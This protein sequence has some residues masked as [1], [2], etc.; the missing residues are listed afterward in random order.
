MDTRLANVLARLSAGAA[1]YQPTVAPVGQ[2]PAPDPKPSVA[3]YP[4][5][6]ADQVNNSTANTSEQKRVVI[7]PAPPGVPAGGSFSLGPEIVNDVPLVQSRPAE[8]IDHQTPVQSTLAGIDG[9]KVHFSNVVKQANTNLRSEGDLAANIAVTLGQDA[10][11]STEA[12]VTAVSGRIATARIAVRKGALASRLPTQGMDVRLS[13]LRTVATDQRNYPEY[14]PVYIPS[15]LSDAGGAALVSLMVVG[16]PG[17]YVWRYPAAS[18]IDPG[19]QPAGVRWRWPGGADRMLVVTEDDRDWNVVF[20]GAAF[21]N[22]ALTEVENYYRRAW[23]DGIFDEGW[24]TS[25]ALTGVYARP[26]DFPKQLGLDF[27]AKRTTQRWRIDGEDV[28]G[29]PAWDGPAVIPPPPDANTRGVFT[30]IPPSAAAQL[31]RVAYRAWVAAFGDAFPPEAR[32]NADQYASHTID[33]RGILYTDVGG[34][35]WVAEW[36]QLTA[37]ELGDDVLLPVLRLAS[38]AVLHVPFGE[39]LIVDDEAPEFNPETNPVRNVFGQND[40]AVLL[41]PRLRVSSVLALLAGIS[42]TVPSLPVQ[43]YLD[44]TNMETVTT[45]FGAHLHFS[46][47]MSL[48][49]QHLEPAVLRVVPLPGAVGMLGVPKTLRGLCVPRMMSEEEYETGGLECLENGAIFQTF[50]NTPYAG[51]A[52]DGVWANNMGIV[53]VADPGNSYAGMD[54]AFRTTWLSGGRIDVHT[55]LQPHTQIGVI[56]GAEGLVNPFA[57]PRFVRGVRGVEGLRVQAGA[58]LNALVAGRSIDAFLWSSY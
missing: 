47:I 30:N 32:P 54:A 55:R 28:D 9:A 10:V 4:E 52:V 22:A 3:D 41:L 25:F 16:G 49:R 57:V 18:D 36:A 42:V 46:F 29:N 35:I 15:G 7:S 26:R 56:F 43:R 8:G 39:G 31:G 21:S 34:H 24:R 38:R 12:T 23:G 51:F 53:D 2:R 13:T 6:E 50:R 37:D 17:A 11:E 58:G 5:L 33:R 48:S 27:Q 1:A 14:V 19:I 44:D 40:R 20:G 45:A